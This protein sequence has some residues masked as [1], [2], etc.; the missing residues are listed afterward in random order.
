MTR[1]YP[2]FISQKESC[3]DILHGKLYTLYLYSGSLLPRVIN[4]HAQPADLITGVFVAVGAVGF[5]AQG[6]AACDGEGLPVDGDAEFAGEGG[7]EFLRASRMRFGLQAAAG[8]YFDVEHLETARG[9]KGEDRK[10]AV[11]AAVLK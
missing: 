8:V 11:E 5:E 9:V 4:D 3:S 6:G 1:K 7:D 2:V 10:V